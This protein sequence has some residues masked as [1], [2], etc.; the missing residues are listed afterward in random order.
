MLSSTNPGKMVTEVSQSSLLS[1]QQELFRTHHARD[2]PNMQFKITWLKE[3]S[4]T[5][6]ASS[7]PVL[8]P[9]CCSHCIFIFCYGFSICNYKALTEQNIK[10]CFVKELPLPVSTVIISNW[11]FFMLLTGSALIKLVIPV[12]LFHGAPDS[13][14][15]TAI[16]KWIA[17]Q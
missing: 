4:Q 17:M 9:L 15:D 10:T 16:R 6:P 7:T 2:H 11:I 8:A 14:A 3:A 1:V 12:H 13:K 5:P